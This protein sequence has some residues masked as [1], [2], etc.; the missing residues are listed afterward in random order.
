MTTNRFR[1]TPALASLCL[2]TALLS[3]ACGEGP[4]YAK[5]STADNSGSGGQRPTARPRTNLPMPP[6]ATAHDAAAGNLGGWTMLDGRRESVGDYRGRVLMLDFYATYCPP[7]RDEIPHLLALRRRF[8]AQG[9]EVVGL[10]VGG[11]ADQRKVPEFVS[12]LGISYPLANPDP[13]LVDALFGGE[14]AIPQTFVFDRR[15]RLVEHVT[16]FDPDIAARLESAVER[17]VAGGE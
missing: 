8:A 17:A 9:L 10:N 2:L 6:V 5:S 7:C 11:E 15:G 14:T 3:S 4:R 16:G 12:D 1:H 13:S